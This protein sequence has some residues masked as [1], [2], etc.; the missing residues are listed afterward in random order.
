ME[1]RPVGAGREYS[2]GLGP[3]AILRSEFDERSLVVAHRGAS[4]TSPENTIAAFEAAIRAGA[5]VIELDV[6]LT[7]DGIPVILHDPD[8]SSTTDGTGLVHTLAL[9]E[10]KRLDASGKGPGHLEIPTLAEA[11]EAIGRSGRVAADL[12]IK[13]IP[14]EPAFDSPDESILRASLRVLEDASFSGAVLISSFNWITIERA[15]QLAPEVPTGFLTLAPIDPHAALV[16]AGQHGHDFVLP[17]A[18]ALLEGGDRFVE[19]AHRE[20]IR[21]GTWTVDDQDE[22]ALLFGWGVDAVASND[23]GLAVAV[24]DRV[25]AP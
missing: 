12:E 11:L 10:V 14:G 2:D 18:P 19:D 4:S 9:G 22:L 13:N 21:V 3:V 15:K 6:R 20:G 16:Y 23:P 25:A 17:Q 8:V 5:D 24:R 7:A 1:P